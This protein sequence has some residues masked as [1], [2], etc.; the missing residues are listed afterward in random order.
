M[1][2]ILIIRIRIAAATT[3][4]N[5]KNT[6]NNYTEYPITLKDFKEFSVCVGRGISKFFMQKLSIS[7]FNLLITDLTNRSSSSHDDTNDN[8][9]FN[10]TLFSTMITHSG[11][12]TFI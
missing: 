7:T 1:I 9:F 4:T 8:N 11:E 12:D 10:G 5:T 6:T 3:T 2:V